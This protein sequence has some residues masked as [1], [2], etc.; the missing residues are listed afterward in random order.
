MGTLGVAYFTPAIGA[1]PWRRHPALG[2][3][4]AGAALGRQLQ[5][6]GALFGEAGLAVHPRPSTT[7]QVAGASRG[8]VY[9]LAMVVLAIWPLVFAV[10]G[11]L[12]YALTSNAKLQEIGRITFFAG[13]FWLVAVLAHQVVSLPSR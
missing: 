4:A 8:G 6:G 1:A 7:A 10:V 13:L 2:A 9:L 11:V 12:M 3:L 5:A